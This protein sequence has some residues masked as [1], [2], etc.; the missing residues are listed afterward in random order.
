[1]V[2]GATLEGHTMLSSN[3]V[4]SNCC[5][6]CDFPMRERARVCV[7]KPKLAAAN[8]GGM[9]YLWCTTIAS[10]QASNTN[11]SPVN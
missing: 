5:G 4:I 9:E 3:E 2:S 8:G 1:M 10:K 11:E 6:D 7:S